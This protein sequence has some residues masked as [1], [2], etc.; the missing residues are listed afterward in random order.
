MANYITDETN[1]N[2][3]ILVLSTAVAVN[4]LLDWFD[5]DVNTAKTVEE[6][7]NEYAVIL[8]NSLWHVANQR[9]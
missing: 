6:M 3:I 8:A 7:I 5:K 1:I 9:A 2:Y 4:W